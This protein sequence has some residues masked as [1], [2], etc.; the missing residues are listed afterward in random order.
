MLSIVGHPVA[1]NP[2]ATL[3]AHANQNGWAT[4]DF[5]RREQVKRWA[6][7]AVAGAGGIALGVAVGY[8]LGI[9]RT[10]SVA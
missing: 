8:G 7:P 10:R 2:D 4:R 3:R 1:V 6:L 5:R 9:S